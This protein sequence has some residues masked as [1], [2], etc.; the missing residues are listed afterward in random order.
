MPTLV[1]QSTQKLNAKLVSSNTLYDFIETVKGTLPTD[2]KEG[3]WLIRIGANWTRVV[4]DETGIVT[5]FPVLG[6]SQEHWRQIMQANIGDTAGEVPIYM[7]PYPVII[8]TKMY[9]SAPAVGSYTAGSLL[10]IN[11]RTAAAGIIGSTTDCSWITANVAA[12]I[13]CGRVLVNPTDHPQGFL[14]AMISFV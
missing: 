5:C 9:D 14:R 3:E 4:G 10:Y 6:K 11:T 8:E 2:I 1:T 7:G 13:P 12:A